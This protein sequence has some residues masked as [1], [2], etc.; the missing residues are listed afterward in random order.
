[1]GATLLTNTVPLW[2]AWSLQLLLMAFVFHQVRL[3]A[4][5]QPSLLLACNLGM[6]LAGTG[7]GCCPLL[8]AGWRQPTMLPC[9]CLPR[10]QLQSPEWP[11]SWGA[12]STPGTTGHGELWWGTTYVLGD[13]SGPM[14]QSWLKY[15]EA[16][17]ASGLEAVSSETVSREWGSPCPY[18]AGSHQSWEVAAAVGGYTHCCVGL[19]HSGTGLQGTGVICASWKHHMLAA[20]FQQAALFCML[21]TRVLLCIKRCNQL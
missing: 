2:V 21:Y 20:G 6:E 10:A 13:F 12:A 5:P 19:Q 4:A 1:M 17:R 8:G 11:Q 18:P 3:P 9:P 7:A 14:L 15:E 16:A